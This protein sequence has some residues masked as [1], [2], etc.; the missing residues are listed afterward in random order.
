[1]KL[2][3]NK[4]VP[5]IRFYTKRRYIRRCQIPA[6][7]EFMVNDEIPENEDHTPLNS[8]IPTQASPPPPPR[9]R[10]RE[11]DEDDD[12]PPSKKVRRSLIFSTACTV[13]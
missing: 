7:E 6:S 10:K 11:D 5:Y 2:R 4:E 13:H 8:P 12:R 3:S 9:K 1:M